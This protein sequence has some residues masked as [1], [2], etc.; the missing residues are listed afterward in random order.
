MNSFD[1]QELPAEYVASVD[2]VTNQL[3]YNFTSELQGWTGQEPGHLYTTGAQQ[4][5][6]VAGKWRD[7]MSVKVGQRRVC[8]RVQAACVYSA[9]VRACVCVSVPVCRCAQMLS[10]SR[11]L[12]LDCVPGTG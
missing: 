9:S 1:V 3:I 6:K 10:V 12:R 7:I 11:H 2:Y 5:V 4:T 8:V